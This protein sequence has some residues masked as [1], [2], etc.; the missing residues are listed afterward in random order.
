MGGGDRKLVGSVA[1][2]PVDG[3]GDSD[4]EGDS[5][6]FAENGIRI[7]IAEGAS[8]GRFDGF[9]EGTAGLLE[10]TAATGVGRLDGCMDSSSKGRLEGLEEGSTV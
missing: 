3:A 8:V 1:L 7:G 4:I 9:T 5:E 2:E 10:S 6:I